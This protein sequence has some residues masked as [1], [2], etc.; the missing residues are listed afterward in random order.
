[1]TALFLRPGLTPRLE[2]EERT[3]DASLR[4]IAGKAG[5]DEQ[6]IEQDVSVLLHVS[7]MHF[8]AEDEPA[9]EALVKLAQRERPQALVATGDITQNA[10]PEEFAAAERFF[11]RLVVPHHLIVPGSHDLPAWYLLRR[12]VAP[13]AA[14]RDAFGDQLEPRLQ[15]HSVW[16]AGLR[17]TRRWRHREGTLSEAQV[18][19]TAQWLAKAP[20]GVLRVVAMHHPV[21]VAP[22]LDDGDGPDALNNADFAVD[23][24]ARAGVHVVLSGHTHLP[25]FLRLN[26]SP[27]GAPGCAMPMWGVQAGTAVSQHLRG[28]QPHSPHSLNLLRRVAAT[29]WRM[30]QWTYAVESGEFVMS[31]WLSLPTSSNVA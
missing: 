16:V 29:G 3:G 26:S 7:D 17:T 21:A 1:M 14:F 25:C 18:L 24:W 8:G 28:Q 2:L 20:P 13:Y 23:T 27:T 5:A 31:D 6:P 11:G 10:K 15:S 4:E 12:L 22:E 30:E 9:L 19:Q